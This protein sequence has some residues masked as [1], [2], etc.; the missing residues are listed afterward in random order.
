MTLTKEDKI[1]LSESRIQKAKEFLE[2]ARA[3]LQDERI[4]T[5]VNRSYYAALNA[6]RSL[7]ILEGVNAESHDGAVTLFSLRFIKTNQLPANLVKKF[8]SLLARRTEVDYGDFE[9]IEK[10]EA[11]E[12]LQISEEII[13]QID[14]LRIKLIKEL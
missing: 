13:T 10:P 5:S 8:K 2:D 12:S 4:K 3:T 6:V 1:N 9:M 7:L 14:Q 11:E